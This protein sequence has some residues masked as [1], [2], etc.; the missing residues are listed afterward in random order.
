ML[1][2][3]PGDIFVSHSQTTRVG[4]WI[5]AV[6]GMN[7]DPAWANHTGGIVVGGWAQA[8]EIVEATWPRTRRIRFWLVYGPD[9]GETRPE[10]IV[11]RPRNV[12]PATLRLIVLKLQSYVGRRY[13]LQGLFLHAADALISRVRARD[14]YVFRRIRLSDEVECSEA[15]GRSFAAYGYLFEKPKGIRLSPDDIDDFCRAN[16]DKYELVYGPAQLGAPPVVPPSTADPAIV[17]GSADPP[18]NVDIP[19]AT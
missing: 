1:D 2:F 8:A 19:G 7:G 11:Y 10:V 17:V 16:P 5:R 15:I 9:A 12:P 6:L 18:T 14:T 3:R 4:R 13:G